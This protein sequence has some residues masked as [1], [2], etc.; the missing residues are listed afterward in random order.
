MIWWVPLSWVSTF[1]TFYSSI[2]R[3]WLLRRYKTYCFLKEFDE[4]FQMDINEM[5]RFRFLA[6]VNITLQKIHYCWQSKDYNSGRKKRKLTAVLFEIYFCIWKMSICPT[7]GPFWS[8][9]YLD[10]GG[11]SCEIK[12]LSFSIQETYTLR[13]VKNQALLFHS[14]WQPKFVWFHGWHTFLCN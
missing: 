8:A 4:V 14:N 11:E 13:K 7:F 1:L 2:F 12:I 9:M 6:V 3:E 5:L 10:F